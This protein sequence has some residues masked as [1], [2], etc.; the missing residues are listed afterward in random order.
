[1]THEKQAPVDAGSASSG[2]ISLVTTDAT[3]YQINPTKASLLHRVEREIWDCRKASQIPFV[4]EI[5]IERWGMLLAVRE[6]L[7]CG[8]DHA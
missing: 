4:R 8:G 1:M 2:A 7:I 6:N 3:V 5:A